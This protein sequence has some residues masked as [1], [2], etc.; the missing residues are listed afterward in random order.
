VKE[1]AVSYMSQAVTEGNNFT[2][3]DVIYDD[4]GSN[5]M[6]ISSTCSP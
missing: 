2:V 6:K 1:L 3:K 5:G 4:Y